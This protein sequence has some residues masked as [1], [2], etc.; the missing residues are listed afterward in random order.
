MLIS[1]Y[2]KRNHLYVQ[3]AALKGA[4]CLLESVAKTNTTIGGVSEEIQ[5]LRNVIVSY[6]TKFGIVDERYAQ[7]VIF[8]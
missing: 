3:T 6:V 4:L 8:R 2:L 7:I 1:E 5:I